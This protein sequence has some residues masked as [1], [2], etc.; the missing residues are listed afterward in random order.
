MSK[1][2]FF[3]VAMAAISITTSCQKEEENVPVNP[4]VNAAFSFDITGTDSLTVNFTNNSTNGANY[5]WD[6]GDGNTSNDENPT[7]TYAFYKSYNV[8]LT[9]TGEDGSTTSATRT[10][11]VVGDYLEASLGDYSV[12]GKFIMGS[13][14]QNLQGTMSVQ[15]GAG[16]NIVLNVDGELIT[17]EDV[18]LLDDGFA[19][20]LVPGAN[21]SGENRTGETVETING[22]PYH[23][24]F[25][26][27]ASGNSTIHI[28]M[29]YKS[30]GQTLYQ[31]QAILTKM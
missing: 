26:F 3:I 19:F 31:I 28:N 18:V 27:N 10:V 30:G 23:G 11:N 4:A 9:V 16:A 5:E 21:A 25:R 20:N 14:S 7:H 12:G 17:T 2:L 13:S 6:F 15:K 22:T 8:K 24:R 1:N 29:V